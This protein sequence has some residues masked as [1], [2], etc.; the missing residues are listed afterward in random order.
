[1]G[2]RWDKAPR[3][4]GQQ[5][6]GAN[7][8]DGEPDPEADRRNAGQT[9]QREGK[10]VQGDELDEKPSDDAARGS[11]PAPAIVTGGSGWPEPRREQAGQTVEV[12]EVPEATGQHAQ[13][14]WLDEGVIHC[15]DSRLGP[16]E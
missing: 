5:P 12:R 3:A 2:N 16:D 10:E 8:D 4:Q 6:D 13:S 7:Q 9:E 1:M 14:Q 11:S 15:S